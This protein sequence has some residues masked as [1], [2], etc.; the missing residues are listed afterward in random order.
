MLTEHSTGHSDKQRLLRAPLCK[1]PTNKKLLLFVVVVVIIVVVV[2]VVVAVVVVVVYFCFVI[3]E[4]PTFFQT[5]C[6]LL[7]NF[8]DTEEEQQQ[9]Q[10]QRQ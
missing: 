3:W 5:L 8:R 4:G 1:F 10:Q 2:V 9:Q 6:G 7:T